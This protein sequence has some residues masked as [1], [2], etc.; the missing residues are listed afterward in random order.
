MSIKILCN[1]NFNHSAEISL[2]Q[3]ATE[4]IPAAAIVLYRGRNTV[5]TLPSRTVCIKSFRRPGF[6]KAVL[7]GFFRKPKAVRAYTNAEKLRSLGINTPEPYGAVVCRQ[8]GLL[9]DSYYVCRQ[10]N[11]W[12]HLRGIEKRPDFDA[13]AEALAAFMLRLHRRGV[14]MKDFSQ[15]NV[16]FQQTKNGYEFALVDIN[17]MEFSVTDRRRL[18]DNFGAAL[19]TEEAMLTLAEKYVAL[20]H[21]DEDVPAPETLVGIFRNRQAFLRRKR[22]LKEYIKGKKKKK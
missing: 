13:L 3:L 1:S 19:D 9:R 6:F 10:L 8:A 5:A 21:D 22:R 4:G 12:H 16:L 11:G 18:L 14:L 15:G 2:R 7:Y 20:A 17:R